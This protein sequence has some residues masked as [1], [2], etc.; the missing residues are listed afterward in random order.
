LFR[1]IWLNK[2]KTGK[3]GASKKYNDVAIKNPK[4][5]ADKSE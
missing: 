2:E 4:I 1:F 5:S 3:K